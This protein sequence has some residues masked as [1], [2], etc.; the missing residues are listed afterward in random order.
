M[1]VFTCQSETTPGSERPA[2]V[3]G[4]I[5]RRG[6]PPHEVGSTPPSSAGMVRCRFGVLRAGGIERLG[7]RQPACPCD[8]CRPTGGPSHV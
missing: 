5:R 8:T 1:T 6:I 2:P 7:L 3:R 4:D